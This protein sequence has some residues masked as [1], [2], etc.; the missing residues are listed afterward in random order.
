MVD[1]HPEVQC[2]TCI[3]ILVCISV[4]K[5]PTTLH[6]E[7]KKKAVLLVKNTFV[8]TSTHPPHR[9]PFNMPLLRCTLY[10][11]L[12]PSVLKIVLKAS[13]LPRYGVGLILIP[14][15]PPLSEVDK[16]DV[17]AMAGVR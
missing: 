2:T 1:K 9:T 6:R 15:P 11:P 7:S 13:M 4:G 16:F 8:L 5:R 12:S 14:L 10:I 3:L 17:T